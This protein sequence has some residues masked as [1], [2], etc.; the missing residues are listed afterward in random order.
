MSERGLKNGVILQW[1]NNATTIKPVQF[2]QP[3]ISYFL[4][5]PGSKNPRF[6]D[7]KV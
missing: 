4:E 1:V 6:P 5:I 7:I 2:P 3:E